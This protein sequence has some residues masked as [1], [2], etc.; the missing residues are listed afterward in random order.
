[1]AQRYRIAVASKII[2]KFFFGKEYEKS[3]FAFPCFLTKKLVY[4]K[5]FALVFLLFTLVLI[6]TASLMV[7][8]TG[9]VGS[10]CF[11]WLQISTLLTLLVLV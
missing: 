4:S 2:T 7:I 3:L 6:F 10:S 8:N 1:M 11:R 5:Q 9:T